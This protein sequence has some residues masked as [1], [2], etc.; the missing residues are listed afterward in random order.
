[1]PH[2]NLIIV[3]IVRG[4]DLDCSGTELH[5]DGDG[6]GDDGEAPGEEGVEGEFAVEVLELGAG[7]E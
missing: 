4:R 3:R 7:S 5:V 2:S 6:V 1:M